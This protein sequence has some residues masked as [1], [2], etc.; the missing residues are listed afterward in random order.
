MV[1]LAAVSAVLSITMVLIWQTRRTYPG[2]ALWTAGNAAYAVGFLAI[3]LR[4]TIPDLL[5]ILLANV[6]ILGA[7]E[8]YLEGIR[9]FRG[10]SSFM[11]LNE[12]FMILLI[13]GVVYFTVWHDHV[14][15]RVILFSGCAGVIFGLGALVLLRNPPPDQ[16]FS[17][18]LTGGLFALFSLLLF[19]R[20][21][22]TVFIS[23]P[24]DLLALSFFQTI[25]LMA[26]LLMGI[27]WTFGFVMLNSERLEV[28][29]KNAQVK[30]QRLA[31][32]D[33]LTG[34]ANSRSFFETGG[35]EIQRARRYGHPL[36]VLMFD[37]DHFKR[38]NDTYGHAAGDRV[39]LAVTATCRDI[40]RD[41]DV[42][43]R[44][45]G[46]EFAMLLPETDLAGGMATAERLR[47][48]IAETSVDAGGVAL[49]VTI[50]IG[51]AVLLPEDIRVEE[52]LK[53]ADDAM[54][55]AKR[56]GRNRVVAAGSAPPS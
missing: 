4:G 8:L 22:H 37:L 56:S 30:L 51:V 10:L 39:L 28:D 45:G 41:I 26:A 35:R 40:L 54:Y 11:V 29:L 42:F 6:F 5:S 19:T 44:I 31:T 53:R 43:G 20:V 46:E 15:M 52:P 1:T 48:A 55:E 21:L 13:A 24:H 49:Q 18:R 17:F 36:A 32:T 27:A 25:M 23:G 50:S 16:R 34:I 38:I 3:A 7:A 9:R 2:F 47:T 12:F 33:F 14:G